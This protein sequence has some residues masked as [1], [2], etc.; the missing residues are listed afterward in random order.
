MLPSLVGSV[1]EEALGS[2]VDNIASVGHAVIDVADALARVGAGHAGADVDWFLRRTHLRR[3]GIVH[4][5]GGGSDLMVSHDEYWSRT[6]GWARTEGS[7][8]H[9]FYKPSTPPSDH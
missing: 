2:P 6:P 7:P 3:R 5:T 8:G 1:E 9:S 4:M